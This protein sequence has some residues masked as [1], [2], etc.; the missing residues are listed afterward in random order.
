MSHHMKQKK[1]KKKSKRRKTVGDIRKSIRNHHKYLITFLAT[2]K[3]EFIDREIDITSSGYYKILYNEQRQELY[4]EWKDIDSLINHSDNLRELCDRMCKLYQRIPTNYLS[5]TM[6]TEN[7]NIGI[8]D[9]YEARVTDYEKNT[10]QKYS[11]PSISPLKKRKNNLIVT[12]SD[13][14]HVEPMN[15]ECS[16]INKIGFNEKFCS[17]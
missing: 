8:R 2:S 1:K 4:N 16:Q 10:N 6:N 3:R 15:V 14:G 17:E 9:K 7:K 13:I 12:V 5:H 11:P